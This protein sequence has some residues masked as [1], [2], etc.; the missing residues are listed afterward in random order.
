MARSLREFPANR[1]LRCCVGR[2][3]FSSS[4][5]LGEKNEWAPIGAHFIFLA[6]RVGLIRPFGPHPYGAHYMRPNLLCRFVEQASHPGPS[7]KTQKDPGGAF[8]EF[9]RRG[10][11]SNPRKATNLC[12][13]SRPVHSTTLPPLQTV[14]PIQDDQC[15]DSARPCASPCGRIHF[16]HASKIVP[17]DFVDHSATSP[18]DAAFCAHDGVDSTQI[19]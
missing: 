16:A 12:W 2:A 17:D 8:F 4:T 19:G 1:Q 18:C 15:I 11:D 7:S 3:V 5:T 14:I 6:E 13:F 9:W 10:W